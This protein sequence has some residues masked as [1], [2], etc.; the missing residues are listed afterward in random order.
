MRKK[1]RLIHVNLYITAKQQEILQQRCDEEGYS[2]AEII[3]RA[4]D[5][6][7]GIK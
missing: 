5:H 6:Y 2:M 4:L 3:R 7:L 1:R